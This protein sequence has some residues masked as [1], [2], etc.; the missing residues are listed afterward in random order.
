[1]P[2]FYKHIAPTGL[3]K[4]RWHCFYKHI[5]PTGLKSISH[6]HIVPTGLKSISHKHIVPTGLKSIFHSQKIS[7]LTPI[8]FTPLYPTDDNI[9]D[10]NFIHPSSIIDLTILKNIY[11]MKHI[12][13]IVGAIYENKVFWVF[14]QSEC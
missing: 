12:Y 10:K 9:C 1:M 13:F 3:K 8:G 4:C 7:K 6:K 11:I 14:F 5:V 2:R